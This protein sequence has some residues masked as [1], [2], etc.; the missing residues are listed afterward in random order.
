MFCA[1]R[2]YVLLNQIAAWAQVRRGIGSQFGV[3]QAKPLVMLGGHHHITHAGL[4]SQPR[5]SARHVRRRL[6]LLAQLLV[7]LKR[8]IL[9]SH[10]P[11][12]AA[13]N[14]VEAPM[15]EH[16]ELGFTPP[17]DAALM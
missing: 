5:P 7:L 15:N 3:K 8:D 17:L 9:I 13:Q 4:A 11:S 2:F 10:G 14:A 12:V 1:G 6:K 16:S